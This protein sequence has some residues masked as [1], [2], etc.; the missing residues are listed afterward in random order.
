MTAR[1]L[2]FQG[3]GSDVGKSLI[4]AGLCRLFA[5][6]GL[7]VVPFKAQN[8]S[9]N[10]AVTENGG[11]IGRA[12]WLQALAAGVAPSVHMN[13]ILLKPQ[14]NHNSQ[15]IVQGKLET[16]L[17]AKKYHQI[18][19]K[20]MP[21][22]LESFHTLAKNADLV[23]VEG[24]G[25]P[26]EINLRENDIAN[27]G[28]ARVAPCPVILIGD[29]DRGGVIA[30]IAGTHTVLSDADKAMIHG[31]IINK[32]RG[33]AS[34]FDGGAKAIEHFTGWKNFGLVPYHQ[35]LAQL[36]QEDSLALRTKPSNKNGVTIAILTA[37]HI[38]NFDDIDPLANEANINLIW[39]K[40][41]DVIPANANLVI[42]PG[43]KSTIAD[44]AFIR[45][46]GWDIDLKAHARR[47][48]RI[49]GICGGYQMLGKTLSD[50]YG[51][52]GNPASVEGLGLLDISTIFTRE[53]TVT[54]WQGKFGD[55][56]ISGYEI[57]V[58]ISEG[59]DCKRPVFTSAKSNE[60]AQS[61]DG[62]IWGSY[63]HGVFTND[64]FRKE[65]LAQLGTAPSLYR[66]SD[67]MQIILNSWADVLEKHVAIE[68]LM[69]L[70]APIRV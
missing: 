1:A 34:L 50:P 27:M 41:G 36:P 48:G 40:E 32:F 3:T 47:G 9:N 30:S 18:R 22:V 42:L 52:E 61:P 55:K 11:E 8:M 39:C 66:Y 69:S 2:M 19:V 64:T 16:T 49:I 60:G 13:P 12:Q 45:A 68:Q 26:A 17:S 28:F 31:F 23:L 10:A 57:H 29:I 43:S 7:R 54:P 14:S 56:D 25:S 21:R 5:R 63:I 67:H 51:V 20:F 6:R 35:P 38:A 70:A 59:K 53:K 15:V 24:A 46:Q 44:L 62:N 37:P 58:G 33:D 4:V 65:L